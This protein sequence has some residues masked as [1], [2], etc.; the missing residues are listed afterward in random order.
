MSSTALNQA[1][2]TP[3]LLR[4]MT[5]LLTNV[6]VECGCAVGSIH[7]D[8]LER[9]ADGTRIRTTDIERIQRYRGYWTFWTSSY[10]RYLIISFDGSA[11]YMSF[12]NYVL[13]LLKGIYPAPTTR[14]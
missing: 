4:L 9:F 12:T 7:A 11:G 13:L 6:R 1:L 2:D 8:V 10:S 14:Q 5:A 3:E